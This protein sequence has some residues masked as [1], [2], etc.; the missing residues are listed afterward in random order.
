MMLHARA[1]GLALMLAASAA[2]SLAQSAGSTAPAVGWVLT[3]AA[4]YSTA[5][6]DNV[7]I[8]GEGDDI[9]GDLMN[10][11][12]PRIDISR[13]G[14][15]SQFG[16][17]YDGSILLY[18]EVG[19]LNSYDQR[20][21][22]WGRR[23][24]SRRVTI[25]A[26]N[27]FAALP[28]TQSTEFVGVPFVRTGSTIDDVQAG[29]DTVFSKR[30]TMSAAYNFQWVHFDDDP[31]LTTI[32]RG[33][34]SNGGSVSF[35]HVISN[36]LTAV[37]GYNLTHSNVTETTEAFIVQNADAGFDYRLTEQ[38]NIF[39]SGGISHLSFSAFGPVRVGPSVRAGISRQFEELNA[40]LTYSRSFIPSYGFG[41]TTQN[42]ELSGHVYLP[43]ARR[44]YSQA[45]VTIRGNEPLTTVGQ[46]FL[47]SF[48][49]EASVGYALRP[50]L[51]LEGFYGGAH[52]AIDRP[53]GITN[54]NRIGV[55]L[56]TSKPM[57]V[58]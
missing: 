50:S 18:R 29:V 41:G 21:S 47:R 58:H 27:G 22:V 55:Q 57:R 48:W 23:Q 34:Y 25:F 19:D 31:T 5:W 32:L 45:S 20:M 39:A 7:Y 9:V 33:G 28:T 14:R 43:L 42:E 46:Q 44:L 24:L 30:T 49:I 11:V 36:R 53:G 12:N 17:N 35:R 37:A 10:V 38:V 2:P 51:H 8:L 26:R 52:Q 56:V 15:H 16:A 40:S 6:D 1:F 13:T 54:R 4:V 3:P